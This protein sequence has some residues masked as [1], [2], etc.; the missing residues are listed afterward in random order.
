[1]E[2][3]NLIKPERR[4]ELDW[5]RVLAMLTVFLFHNARFFDFMDWHVKNTDQSLIPMVFVFFASQWI[6]PFFFLLAGASTRFA[7]DFQTGGKFIKERFLRLIVPFIFGALVLIP[8]QGYMEALTHIKYFFSGTFWQY[9]PHHFQVRLSWFSPS[10]G[11]LFGAFG[12]HLWFLGFLFLFSLLSLPLFRWL[13]SI[14]GGALVSRFGGLMEK[15]GAIFLFIFPIALAQVAL[16]AKFPSYLDLADLFYWL[17]FFIGG[18][19]IY[20]D[21]RCIEAVKRQGKPALTIG[22]I[23]F[24]TMLL[25]YQFGHLKSW[26]DHPGYYAGY[27][28]YQVIRSIH[29]WAWIVYFLS[30]GMRRLNF[31]NATLKYANEAVLPFYIPHQTVIL[32]IGFFVVRLPL[33][34]PLKYL[35][36]ATSSFIATMAIYEIIKRFAITRFLF[37]MRPK[38][39]V[40]AESSRSVRL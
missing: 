30:L 14:K 29:T 31:T 27:L 17:V 28:I 12:Y 4:Y 2:T 9:Y 36:I 26:E 13:R 24:I 32:L 22:I 33:G 19:L 10:P 18:Y 15:P 38:K 20:A 35:I 37:G 11:W 8:P 6:M 7:L 40:A 23:G 1:M 34:I 25:L 21:N 3:T 39:R 5:L 16:R